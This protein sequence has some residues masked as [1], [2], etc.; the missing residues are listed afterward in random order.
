MSDRPRAPTPGVK[1]ACLLAVLAALAA[2]PA[3]A[4]TDPVA[5]VKPFIGTAGTQHTFP[6][7]ATPFGMVQL[8]PDTGGTHGFYLMA[9]WKWCAGYNWADTTILGFSHLHRSGMGA[10]DWGDVLVMPTVGALHVRPGEEA[11]PE[12]GYRSRFRHETEVARPGYYTVTLDDYGVRAELTAAPRA[13]MHRYT[14]PASDAAHVIID[15]GHGLGDTPLGGR[16]N[17]MG[18]DQVV[19][20]RTSTGFVPFQKV[21]FCARFSKPFASFGAWDGPMKMPGV[22]YAA[23]ARIGAFLNYATADGETVVVKVG[24][25]FTSEDEAC[26]NLDHDLPDFDFDAAAQRAGN[27][28]R[29]E[30]AKISVDP[31]PLD[32]PRESAERLAVFYTALYHSL[33]F[34]AT[35]SDADGT[36]AV[37]GNV[38]GRVKRA[39]GWVYYSDYSLWDT[40]RAQMP[41]L[42]LL[43]PARAQDMVRTLVAQ[44]ED[45]GRLPSP[46]SFGNTHSEGMIGDPAAVFIADAYLKGLRGFD[47]KAAYQGMLKNAT[48]PPVN[49]IPMIGAGKGRWGITRY[50]RLGYVPADHALSPKNPL[51]IASYAFNQGVSRTLEYA[52]ADF[53]VS[54]LARE[55]GHQDDYERFRKRAHNFANVFDPAAGFMRGKSVTGKWMNAEDFDPTAY[56]AYYTEGNA[57]QW[58]WS[59][60]HDVA[61]LIA[62][63]GGRDKFNAKLD[64]FFAAGSEVNATGLFSTHIAGMIGQYAHG[65]E[66]SHHIAYL[67]DYSGEPW[68]TEELTR[69]IMDEFYKNEPAGLAGNEDMGQMSAW[70]V[71]SALGLYPLSPGI[72][73]IGSPRFARAELKLDHGAAVVIEAENASSANKYIQSATLNGVPLARP[74]LRHSE[75]ARGAALHFVMGPEPNRA[76]GSAMEDAPPSGERLFDAPVITIA[77]P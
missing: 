43:T 74:W 40:F 13:G 3:A 18:N 59:V 36:Y 32:A 70:Y 31:G 21:S 47:A 34:P 72:Y 33:L 41:L 64:A 19:G 16:I 28:W 12:R 8:S 75:L 48:R 76:W 53:C 9:D 58:T 45:S 30:L 11:E 2:S 67:Y 26:K 56:Y 71:F 15:L 20:T 65:N 46:N 68:K 10:G 42:I 38:P 14:F 17:I 50:Q 39:D 27:E 60:F 51:F 44:F 24:L 61:G 25:S 5:L 4:E 7:A 77:L 1:A 49:I 73:V 62:L 22:R 57:W 37:I 29:R 23:G 6:G 55:T 63:M 54:Y 69:R 52:Y 66:P 35:F